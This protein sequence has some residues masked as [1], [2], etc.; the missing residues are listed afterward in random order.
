V[1]AASTAAAGVGARRE[2]S[3]YA[4]ALMQ[5]RL[6]IAKLLPLSLTRSNDYVALTDKQRE[7][8]TARLL[9]THEL[10]DGS[11]RGANTTGDVRRQVVTDL[12][13]DA[14]AI[15][16]VGSA[17]EESLS[18]WKVHSSWTFECSECRLADY[19]D[20]GVFAAATVPQVALQFPPLDISSW[21]RRWSVEL[22]G[23]FT[24][25]SAAKVFCAAIA[26]LIAIDLLLAALLTMI[27]LLHVTGHLNRQGASA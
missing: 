8:L 26:Q 13:L 11:L 25:L 17:P 15:L 7:S 12:E 3:S 20:P 10:V 5:T 22:Q 1:S 18:A 27:A 6:D 19:I 16:G 24:K 4:E 21:L 9:H 23:T 14:M 2:S